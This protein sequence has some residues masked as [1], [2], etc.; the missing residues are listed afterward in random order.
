MP[1]SDRF[2]SKNT[3]QRILILI[4]LIIFLSLVQSPQGVRSAPN[5]TFTVNNSGDAPDGDLDDNVCDTGGPI[6]P[7][8]ICTLR[9]A[10]QQANASDSGHNTIL[11]TS[12]VVVIAPSNELPA[13][14]NT[15][16]TSIV[17]DQD[18]YLLA[19]NLSS[20]NGLTLVSNNN[21]VMGLVIAGF[22]NGIVVDGHYN[23]IGTDGDASNDSNEGNRIYG[24]ESG[25]GVQLSGDHNVVAGNII[26][27]SDGGTAGPNNTGI[28]VSGDDNR[29]G[30]DGSGVSDNLE[31]NVISGNNQHGID[32][33]GND[34]VVAGNYIG[35]DVDGEAAIANGSNGIDVDP[36]A[37]HTRIGTDGNG[38]GDAAE[39]NIISGNADNG[40]KT[41]GHNVTIAGNYIGTNAA[42]SSAIPNGGYGIEV[43]ISSYGTIIGTDGDASYDGIEGNLISGNTA[44]GVNV[45]GTVQDIWI[46]GNKIGTTPNGNT[47]LGNGDDGIHA[48]GSVTQLVIGTNGDDVSDTSERNII[49]GNGGDG[50]ELGAGIAAAVLA[51][52]RIGT[53]T[54]GTAAVANGDNGVLI[55]AGANHNLVGSDV[56]GISDTLERNLISGNVGSGM[57]IQGSG[58]DYN[59]VTGNYIGTNVSGNAALPNN[60]GV[61]IDEQA[62]QTHIGP[63]L[64]P[65]FGNLISG[66]TNDGIYIGGDSDTT[67]IWHN[68]VGLDYLGTSPLGNGR[69]GI[70][71]TSGAFD[72]DIYNNFIAH[73]SGAGIF[74]ATAAG[75]GNYYS[76]NRIFNNGGLGVDLAPQGVNPNDPGDADSG[77]NDL[78]NYPV[79]TSLETDGS[80]MSFEGTL[81]SVPDTTFQVTAYTVESCDPSGYG[82]GGGESGETNTA[83]LTVKTDSSGMGV[84]AYAFGGYDATRPYMVLSTGL[85]E[86]SKCE[87]IEIVEEV[88]MPRLSIA[89]AA[90]DEGNSGSN[91][92]DFEVTLDRTATITV[93]VSYILTEGSALF[94][95]DLQVSTGTV[96]FPPG[97]TQQFVSIEILGDTL[98]EPDETFSVILQSPQGAVIQDQQATGTILNDDSITEDGHQIFLPGIT[99]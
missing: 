62:Y 51:G 83:T 58:S 90:Q 54:G 29:I 85:S 41:K 36:L 56:D 24:N 65:D 81:N 7:T 40:I 32:I 37:Q 55:G 4:F 95:E 57:R 49:S 89:D 3:T 21:K 53:N 2:S 31:K 35:T 50:V 5:E 30:T 87:L 15:N 16:G 28:L 69:N 74:M 72:S 77:P 98:V 17:A 18:I 71:L 82:E 22:D 48:E 47:G 92:M 12:S 13:L 33:S 93:S 42:G 67:Q 96:Y 79:F 64:N 73:N 27:L 39:R 88:D 34:N 91:W 59:Q 68:R 66:N 63:S 1:H 26:G 45:S 94:D 80:W 78:M 25:Y 19:T 99:R 86:F 11:F 75:S 20:G 38:V 10:I 9:A 61:S 70:Y 76:G 97:T 23:T 44:G 46:A 14:T 84:I 6:H 8:N 52:N 60:I 43:G